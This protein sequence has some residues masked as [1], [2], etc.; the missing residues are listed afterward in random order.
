[1]QPKVFI[2]TGAIQTGKTTALMKWCERKENVHGILTPV[3]DGKRMFID[4]TF[5]EMF[6]ME[7][8]EGETSVVKVGRYVFSGLSFLKAKKAIMQATGSSYLIIDEVGPLELKQEGLFDAVLRA[9]QSQTSPI[10]LVVREGL[11]DNVI[12]RFNIHDPTIITK[13]TLELL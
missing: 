4:M 10:I 1:M 9:L 11:V 5:N 7:A 2:L 13:T 8:I 3:I 6:L 12:E